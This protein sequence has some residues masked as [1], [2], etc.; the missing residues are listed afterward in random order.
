MNPKRKIDSLQDDTSQQRN[1]IAKK[2]A[3]PSNQVGNPVQL[4]PPVKLSPMQPLTIRKTDSPP[5][6]QPMGPP[7]S[8]DFTQ[9]DLKESVNEMGLW[10]M[11]DKRVESLEK[12]LPTFLKQTKPKS[13]DI[14][15]KALTLNTENWGVSADEN[16][17]TQFQRDER[18]SMRKEEAEMSFNQRSHQGTQVWKTDSPSLS[19]YGDKTDTSQPLSSHTPG[20]K[21]SNV[22]GTK[23]AM[24]KEHGT[25]DNRRQEIVSKTFEDTQRKDSDVPI[26]SKLATVQL[27]MSPKEELESARTD[28]Q[29][30]KPVYSI[31]KDIGDISDPNSGNFDTFTDRVQTVRETEKM[32]VAK[33]L[34]VSGYDKLVPTEHRNLLSKTKGDVDEA[35]KLLLKESTS[36]QPSFTFNTSNTSQTPRLDRQ[37][38]RE[39]AQ[40][41]NLPKTPLSPPRRVKNSKFDFN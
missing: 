7:P 15:I 32:F 9:I 22:P 16:V 5:L 37:S 29:K 6:L 39:M 20:I 13:T 8:F 34:L 41:K 28:I 38:L 10:Q 18:S 33:N 24:T 4:R 30:G 11:N 3:T 17:R 35:M 14:R 26:M 19:Q 12:Q 1:G 25:R 36:T 27:F 31:F 2:T 40:E 21:T 23:G